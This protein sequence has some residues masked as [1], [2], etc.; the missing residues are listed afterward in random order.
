MAD[1]IWLKLELEGPCSDSSCVIL[2][3]AQSV[4]EKESWLL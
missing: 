2:F 4:V 1:A 3:V